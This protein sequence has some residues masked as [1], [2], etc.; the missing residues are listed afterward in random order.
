MESYSYVDLFETKGME[1]L[2]LMGFLLLLI[3]LLRYVDGGKRGQG[4][5]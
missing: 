4:G 2:L 3:V 5:A 1:Y